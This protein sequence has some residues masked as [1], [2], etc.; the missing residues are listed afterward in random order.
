MLDDQKEEFFNSGWSEVL[1][2]SPHRQRMV[3]DGRI[4]GGS[5]FIEAVLKEAGERVAESLRLRDERIGFKDLCEEVAKAHRI[6]IAGLTSG[7]SRKAIAKSRE[8]VA[9]LAVKKLGMSGAEVARH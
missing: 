2:L 9:Q 7:S 8:D 6:G 4:L 1:A 3:S 5:E